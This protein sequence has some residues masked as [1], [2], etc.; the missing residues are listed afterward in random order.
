M[1]YMR[2]TGPGGSVRTAGVVAVIAG[3]MVV[4]AAV[5]GIVVAAVVVVGAGV[6]V[7]GAIVVA[8]SW[9]PSE[10]AQAAN[11]IATASATGEVLPW[12]PC[13]SGRRGTSL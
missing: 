13:G 7:V 3:G 12:V 2:P 10:L 5:A 9:A 11:T 6:V 4:A 8:A 1:S